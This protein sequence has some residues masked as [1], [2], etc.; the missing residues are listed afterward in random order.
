MGKEIRMLGFQLGSF[1]RVYTDTN[2][3]LRHDAARPGALQRRGEPGWKPCGASP[4]PLISVS[5]KKVHCPNQRVRQQSDTTVNS[6]NNEN[7]PAFKMTLVHMG[8][9]RH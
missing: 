3:M 2:Y 1:G 7:P 6:I 9:P 5:F 8:K 4:R